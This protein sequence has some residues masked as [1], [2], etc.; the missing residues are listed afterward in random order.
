MN[1][2]YIAEKLW[3]SKVCVFYIQNNELTNNNAKV[4]NT[5]IY[6]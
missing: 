3:A 4:F 6:S 5:L 1:S 2:F